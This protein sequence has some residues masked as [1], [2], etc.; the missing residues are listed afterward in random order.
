MSLCE[1][2]RMLNMC[3]CWGHL[4]TPL[5]NTSTNSQYVESLDSGQIQCICTWLYI[6]I[7]VPLTSKFF[8]TLIN[9]CYCSYY[10]GEKGFSPW[11][12]PSDVVPFQSREDGNFFGPWTAIQQNGSSLLCDVI[13]G[14]H[15]RTKQPQT[16]RD[17]FLLQHAWFV[18]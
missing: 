14:F 7:K 11:I 17:S 10:F 9:F 13:S 5:D 1:I 8:F 18:F 16:E 12:F 2:C 6:I 4:N 3:H 15:S